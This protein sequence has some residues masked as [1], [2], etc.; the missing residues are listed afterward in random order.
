MKFQLVAATLL[1][2]GGTVA[3]AQQ[4]DPD[5][6]PVEQ[7]AATAAVPSAQLEGVEPLAEDDEM[8]EVVCRTE[9]MTGSLSRRR[10]TCMTRGEWAELERNTGQG[11]NEM[12]RNASGGHECRQDQFG[13]C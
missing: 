8:Q 10:R 9:R 6:Q 12:G 2:A 13:G 3:M 11:M 4:A 7:P 1:L 5:Q